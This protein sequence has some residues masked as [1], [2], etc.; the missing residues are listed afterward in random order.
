VIFNKNKLEFEAG[1]SIFDFVESPLRTGFK[2]LLRRVHD[3]EVVEYDR[4]F[5]VNGETKWIH[6][7]ITPVFEGGII[8]GACITGRDIT[9]HKRYVQTIELQNKTLR[10]ISWI[11]SHLVRAPLARIMG[12]IALLPVET[13]E[14]EKEEIINLLQISSAELDEII[15]E[16]TQKTAI[17]GKIP[18]EV[19][20]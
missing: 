9:E 15:K 14:Q 6:F 13:S 7:A 12:L 5:Y 19:N 16:I 18:V 17:T 8:A 2:D 1:R 20:W 10:E 4:D 3:G 11:Q